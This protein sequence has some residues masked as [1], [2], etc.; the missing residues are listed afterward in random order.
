MIRFL[1]M[2]VDVSVVVSA[3]PVR[4]TKARAKASVASSEIST[5]KG[6]SFRGF[7]TSPLRISEK[8]PTF[9]WDSPVSMAPPYAVHGL[10]GY[11]EKLHLI[12]LR[13]A[14]AST[15]RSY[16]G[17]PFPGYG[18]TEASG[19]RD[20]PRRHLLQGE[21]SEG[22]GR[23]VPSPSGD[24]DRGHR[25]PLRVARRGGRQGRR[26][27]G[28]VHLP[29]RHEV[30]RRRGAVHDQLPREGP[31]RRAPVAS[32]GSLTVRKIERPPTGTLREAPRPPMSV[33]TH[34]GHTELTVIPFGDRSRPRIRVNALSETL[35]TEYEDGQPSR[36]CAP[37][38][39]AAR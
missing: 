25:G 20:G 34:P 33:R 27:H 14:S 17:V 16:C 21:G 38:S 26:A 9:P 18:R 36:F 35:D 12:T 15:S 28:L 10:E 29:R 22:D 30:L 4:R 37:C 1:P 7:V 24:S 39:S 13:S 19:P 2:Y 5:T 8:S 32:A 3:A 6:V 11:S 23:M 31:G